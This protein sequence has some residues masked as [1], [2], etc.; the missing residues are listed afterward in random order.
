MFEISNI[1]NK[2]DDLLGERLSKG[3]VTTEDSIRYL[4]FY[5]LSV[6]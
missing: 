4:F 1:F 2:F 6:V 3:I 5:C